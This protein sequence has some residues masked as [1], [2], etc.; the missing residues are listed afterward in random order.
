VLDRLQ[1]A[2]TDKRQMLI[3]DCPRNRSIL[4]MPC[5]IHQPAFSAAQTCIHHEFISLK[6]HAEKLS[7]A[8]ATMEKAFK[9]R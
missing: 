1:N 5:S 6:D 2:A 4:Q 3:L 8:L 9:A 7:I